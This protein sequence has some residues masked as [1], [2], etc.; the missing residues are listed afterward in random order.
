MR[1]TGGKWRIRKQLGAILSRH[2]EQPYIEP[3]VGVA[4]VMMNVSSTYMKTGY[5]INPY[6]IAMLNA[7]RAGWMPP[8]KVSEAKYYK[9]RDEFLQ[10]SAGTFKGKATPDELLGFVGIACA[11]GGQFFTYSYARDRV[12]NTNYADNARKS[13]VPLSY[14]NARFECKDYREI[15]IPLGSVLYCDPPYEHT[16]KSLE[17]ARGFSSDEFWN[18]AEKQVKV[19]HNV[20]VSERVERKG[21]VP[22]WTKEVAST[23]SS[24]DKS[25]KYSEILLVHKSQYKHLKLTPGVVKA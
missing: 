9:M 13:M 3:F 4:S 20:Y 2:S 19:G 23:A 12:G 7:I 24:T 18:W 16:T 22:V 1:Y 8:S 21:W 25:G 10:R 6:V 14:S 11:F 17:F 5:D 15:D